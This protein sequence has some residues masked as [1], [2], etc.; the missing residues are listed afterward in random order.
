MLTRE[1]PPEVYGGAG[2]HVTHLVE[3]LSRLVEVEVHCFGAPRH[4]RQALAHQPWPAISSRRPDEAALQAM[5]VDLLMA[6]GAR[7]ADV[8]HSHTW[9]TNLGG[10]LAGLLHG[11]PHVM[12]AHSLEPLRPW[13]VEQLA[14][15]YELSKFCERSAIEH[16][17][18]V[19]AVSAGMRS[20]ILATYPA[21][22]P[23]RVTVI[24]N[25]ID[26]TAWR[27]DP[28]TDA[29]ER[30]GIDPDLATMVFV[31]RITRQKG[32]DHAIAAAALID[33]AVQVVLCAGAPDTAEIGAEMRTRAA[34]LAESRG[35]V[36]WIEDMLPR[37]DL[38]QILSHATVFICPSEYEPFG[39]T[40]LEAM[41]C[42][43][44]VVASEVGG[45][46]E[47]V[48]DGE[49][50]FLVPLDP[51]PATFATALAARLDA[52]LANPGLAAAMG[53]AGRQRAI[54]HFGWPAVAARTVV[55]YEKA[56]AGR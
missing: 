22:D 5:S 33:P 23:D 27:P 54:D 35:R 50:G 9:Y 44:P 37:S 11:I 45:I 1:Y 32:V 12:T 38:V 26:T 14:G 15:G 2:V 28:R 52:L 16:A 49:T 55:L 29:L 13:K 8:V 39:L 48:A 51:D 53:R 4:D 10:H 36:I 3:E 43:L 24:H 47:I 40:N 18:A 6:A 46:P 41:A 21:I 34:A 25:G 30:F 56:L 17:D 31:G 42:E 7:S 20:D 19:V